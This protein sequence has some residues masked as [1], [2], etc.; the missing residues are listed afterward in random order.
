MSC[1]LSWGIQGYVCL[2]DKLRVYVTRRT[3]YVCYFC[4]VFDPFSESVGEILQEVGHSCFTPHLARGS[5]P[6]KNIMSS[7]LI[8]QLSLFLYQSK[9]P[10]QTG[11]TSILK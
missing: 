6:Y 3:S 10:A 11:L 2:S 7:L 9:H 4:N 8:L 5:F 1:D